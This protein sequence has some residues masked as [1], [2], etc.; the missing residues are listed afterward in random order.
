MSLFSVNKVNEFVAHNTVV[1]C[2]TFGALSHQVSVIIY[3]AISDSELI[4]FQVMAT[5]GEDFNVN[6]WRVGNASNVWTLGNNKSPIEC[7]CFDTEEQCV[8]S[9]AMNGSL[10]VF[11]LNEGRLA[12]NLRGHQ[13][14]INSI[15][16]HPYGEF[17]ASG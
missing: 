8:V 3:W 10:K 2:L 1:N 4:F 14:N 15:H 11:D 17:I 5:G 12:R 7:L 9:G 6:V 13:V 16:Y